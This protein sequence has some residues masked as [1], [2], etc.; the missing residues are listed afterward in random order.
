M[1]NRLG[2]LLA[3]CVL[4]VLLV[5]VMLP[6]AIAQQEH[7][8]EGEIQSVSE[9]FV[10]VLVTSGSLE[11]ETLSVKT[12]NGQLVED[13]SA[14]QYGPGDKVVLSKEAEEN[15]E[16]YISSYVRR[17]SL[18]ALFAVF[19]LLALL[20]GG[21]RGATSLAGLAVS[22]LVVVKVLLPQISA[23]RDPV[24]VSV[25]SSFLIIPATFYLSHGLSK[26]TTIAILGTLFSLV[27]TGILAYYFVSAAHI[28]G[29]ASEEA[30]FLQAMGI[31]SVNMQALVLAGII[32]GLLGV[33][34]DIT[35]A[36][37]AVVEQICIAGD[38]LGR[39]RIFRRSM[40]VGRDHIASMIN[41][42]VLVYAG[43]SL[44][45]LLLFVHNPVPLSQLANY[46]LLAEEI[47]RML[48]GSIGLILAVPVTTGI[49][50]LW[51]RKDS[52]DSRD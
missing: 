42:L 9:N 19:V 52:L 11:G 16:Y 13:V 25:F 45:L 44:P 4:S 6:V 37:A 48:L 31:V 8:L 10:R 1:F 22:F 49:A 38:K 33:L 32:I 29:Y 21:F 17:H 26:K 41:T 3:I 14:P 35:I 20:V 15:A 18:L 43:A 27:I 23:G 40:Q 30:G 47:V 5:R 36:Q 51:F 50:T 2:N 24:L 46:E 12:N 39:G 34:D 28:T 7:V